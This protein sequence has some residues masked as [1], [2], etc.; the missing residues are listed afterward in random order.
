[1]LLCVAAF[2]I[3]LGPA[4]WVLMAELFPTRVR[5]RAM[6]IANVALWIACFVLTFT[7]L[8]LARA[9]TITGAFC[10]YS[11]LCVLTFLLVWRMVPETKGKTLEEIEALWQPKDL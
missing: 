10:L 9:I 11:F 3:G 2:A 8:S 7:F 4:T 6:S 5:G 1:M